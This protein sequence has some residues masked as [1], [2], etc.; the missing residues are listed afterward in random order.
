LGLGQPEL[1]HVQG[2]SYK[3][4]WPK[5]TSAITPRL[6]WNRSI[7]TA[8]FRG[9][10]S[11]PPDHAPGAP[12]HVLPN[13]LRQD[14]PRRPNSTKC[15]TPSTRNSSTGSLLGAAGPNLGDG[16]PRQRRRHGGLPPS[17]PSGPADET[18]STSSLQDQFGLIREPPF[19]HR[20]RE[21]ERTFTAAGVQPNGRCYGRDPQSDGMGS[22]CGPCGSL[23]G[24]EED[25]S[26]DVHPRPADHHVRP[27]ERK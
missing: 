5:V 20:G 21:A 13:Q 6:S 9:A 18:F 15:G 3:A 16:L 7:R 4:P 25:L 22:V 12:R 10:T 19:V 2:D 26:I 11:C 1:P 24:I 8:S 17:P 23:P 27:R 14:Q